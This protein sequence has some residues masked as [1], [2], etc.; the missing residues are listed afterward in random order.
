MYDLIVNIYLAAERIVRDTKRNRS[1]FIMA[2][3]I[4]T[5]FLQLNA[6]HTQAQF[7]QNNPYL[8]GHLGIYPLYCDLYAD[9]NEHYIIVGYLGSN[10]NDG[11]SGIIYCPYTTTLHVAPDPTYFTENMLFLQ[12]YA[13]IRHP[14]DLGNLV[15]DD[16]WNS[17]NAGN[18]DFFKMFLVDFGTNVLVNFSDKSI[19]LF[20]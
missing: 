12:R 13:M 16:P 5:S 20:Q 18:S 6:F 14:Q 4:T 9:V 11:D 10:N 15:P 7:N 2:D 8:V 17:T 19:P 1:V 3:P